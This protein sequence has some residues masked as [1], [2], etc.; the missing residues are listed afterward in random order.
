[1]QTNVSGGSLDSKCHRSCVMN[2]WKGPFPLGRSFWIWQ[3]LNLRKCGRLSQSLKEP[4][5]MSPATWELSLW[6]VKAG[7]G[8]WLMPVFLCDQW[9]SFGTNSP[10]SWQGMDMLS[11][12]CGWGPLRSAPVG[13]NWPVWTSL[14]TLYANGIQYFSRKLPLGLL[15]QNELGRLLNAL[16]WTLPQAYWINGLGGGLKKLHFPHTSWDSGRR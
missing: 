6:H 2:N 7:Q 12:A 13:L 15:H 5:R 10:S 14:R 16:P 1:M 8:L 11:H 9:S 3:R 4:S